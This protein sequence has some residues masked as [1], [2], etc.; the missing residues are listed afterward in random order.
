MQ[1]ITT[2]LLTRKVAAVTF[3][4]NHTAGGVRIDHTCGEIMLPSSRKSMAADPV[5]HQHSEPPVRHAPQVVLSKR[6]MTYSLGV[7]RCGPDGRW[8]VVGVD[9]AIL[10]CVVK[11]GLLRG[12][13]LDKLRFFLDQW[14][15]R[16]SQRGREPE[17]SQAAG[18][19]LKGTVRGAACASSKCPWACA[20]ENEF[21]PSSSL[22][23]Q[24]HTSTDGA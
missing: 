10:K 24:Y 18:D 12:C 6:C 7:R 19:N 16:V 4:V 2:A 3:P 13:E 21:W 9:E 22:L 17:A 14:H 5:A 15:R 23:L 20:F 1:S 11:C 8:A